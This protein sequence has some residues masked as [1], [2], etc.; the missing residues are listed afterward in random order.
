[1]IKTTLTLIL[2]LSALFQPAAYADEIDW[3]DYSALLRQYVVSGEK[4][5]VR[6]NL[7]HY[8]AIAADSRWPRVLEQ[9]AC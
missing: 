9:I 7:V 3:H 1:M 2:L 8:Q 5:G 4:N 6:L